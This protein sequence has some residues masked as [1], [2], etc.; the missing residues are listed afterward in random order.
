MTPSQRLRLPKYASEYIAALEDE[1]AER[2]SLLEARSYKDVAVDTKGGED[3]SCASVKFR[4]FSWHE[5]KLKNFEMS[6]PG[7]KLAWK[8]NGL[9]IRA[10]DPTKG[11]NLQPKTSGSLVIT[12]GREL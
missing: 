3:S 4:Q 10:V 8:N 6:L 12:Q 7:L 5:Y 1:C 2:S 11:L 9:V